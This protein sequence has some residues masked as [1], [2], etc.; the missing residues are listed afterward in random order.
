M[1][2]EYLEAM[3]WR[4]HE[5]RQMAGGKKMTVT[6]KSLAD[7]HVYAIE[8]SIRDYLHMHNKDNNP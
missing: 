4:L 6:E 8:F 1:N 7:A 2:F 3:F 5:A